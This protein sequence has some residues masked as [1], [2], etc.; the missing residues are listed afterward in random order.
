MKGRRQG[1]NRR[2]ETVKFHINADGV[3]Y[4]NG[5]YANT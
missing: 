5:Y 3:H 1:D 2:D 4:A